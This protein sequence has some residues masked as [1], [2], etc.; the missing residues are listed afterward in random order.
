MNGGPS[1]IQPSTN[2]YSVKDRIWVNFKELRSRLRFADVLRLYNVEVTAKGEQYHGPCPLPGH[3]RD[4]DQRCF[5]ANLKRGIFHCFGCGAKG[6][7][8]E[9][10]CLM[11]KADPKDGQAV[12]KV[13]VVLQQRFFPEGA[14]R[15]H[16]SPDETPA[17]ASAPVQETEKPAAAS[18]GD[19]PSVVNEPIDF[20][21]QGLDRSHEYFA[22]NGFTAGTAEYFGLGHCLRG[23]LKGRI[24][25]PLHDAHGRLIGYAGRLVNDSEANPENP[26]YRF[27]SRRERNGRILEFNRSAFL[28]NGHRL[29]VPCDDLIVVEQFPSVW[30]LHQNGFPSAVAL[31]GAASL[32]IQTQ[33]IVE[34]TAHSGRIWLMPDGGRKGEELVLRLLPMISHHRFVRW[35]CLGGDC[36]PTGMEAEEL[37]SCFVL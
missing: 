13:A 5:S 4:R 25:I 9:F 11:E 8:L 32:E 24:A 20:E 22:R 26:L 1:F 31:M 36:Q 28:Y 34:A 37:K 19:L 7:V 3:T 23:M 21:L 18:R 15:R 6:N 14:S 16:P 12:R 35:V 2:G 10:A 33:F 30:W 29:T 17:A 27:P